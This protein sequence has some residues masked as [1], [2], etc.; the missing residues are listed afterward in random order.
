VSAACGRN[1]SDHRAA[2]LVLRE[3]EAQAQAQVKG[4]LPMQLLVAGRAVL[5]DDVGRD[6]A[7]GADLDAIGISPDPNRM[8][9]DSIE[10]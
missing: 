6:S 3:A 2:L 5:A 8:T 4:C 9:I 1:G 10:R 7:A